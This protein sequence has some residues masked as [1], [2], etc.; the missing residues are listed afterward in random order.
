MVTI[1]GLTP[2]QTA[3]VAVAAKGLID[4][5]AAPKRVSRARA[6]HRMRTF[7]LAT[8][9]TLFYQPRRSRK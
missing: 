2:W 4:T 5:G 1:W 7:L 3:G 9:A 8:A 6:A